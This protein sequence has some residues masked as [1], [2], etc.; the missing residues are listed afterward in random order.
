MTVSQLLSICAFHQGHSVEASTHVRVG[1]NEDRN[2]FPFLKFFFPGEWPLQVKPEK[3]LFE[4][5]CAYFPFFFPWDKLH[6]ML[7]KWINV[8]LS[9]ICFL[10]VKILY[11]RLHESGK[12]RNAMHYGSA[13]RSILNMIIILRPKTLAADIRM[14]ACCLVPRARLKCNYTCRNLG[15]LFYPLENK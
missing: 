14:W 13:C 15:K 10:W 8:A 2:L 12:N 11:L 3:S 9:T 5:G 1:R 6:W 7:Q 4:S